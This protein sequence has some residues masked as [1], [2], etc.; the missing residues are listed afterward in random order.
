MVVLRGFLSFY[1]RRS[2]PDALA[3]S[4]KTSLDY[5][6]K[7]SALILRNNGSTTEQLIHYPLTLELKVVREPSPPSARVTVR[8][9]TDEG[10][11]FLI[12]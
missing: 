7:Y 9:V 1:E 8:L 12:V 3:I 2:N 11:A 10:K 5:D 6:S 4:I